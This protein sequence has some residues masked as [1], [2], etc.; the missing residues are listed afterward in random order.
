MLAVDA[1]LNR[2]NLPLA[3]IG[4]VIGSTWVLSGGSIVGVITVFGTASRNGIMLL[5]HICHLIA[6]S[7]AVTPAVAPGRTTQSQGACVVSV[8]LRIAPVAS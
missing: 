6:R 8:D 1:T 5:S 4:G 3:P 7:C 2:L